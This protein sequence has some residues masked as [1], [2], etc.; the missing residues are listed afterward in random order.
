[1]V[2]IDHTPALRSLLESRA[3][4][5]SS[6]SKS[7]SGGRSVSR[8]RDRGK[9]KARSVEDEE[10]E[11]FLKEAYRIVSQSP[12]Y[13]KRSPTRIPVP[14]EVFTYLLYLH[15]PRSPFSSS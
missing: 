9:G 11:A 10:G 2:V 6:R 5:T 4:P 7:P 14:T 12:V 1:M 8:S 3:E 13:L 15:A